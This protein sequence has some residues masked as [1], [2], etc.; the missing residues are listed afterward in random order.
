MKITWVYQELQVEPCHL[1]KGNFWNTQPSHQEVPL[2]FQHQQY[3]P[4][5]LS[6][7]TK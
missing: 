2:S 6:D 7:F 3:L 5:E 4:S 1:E